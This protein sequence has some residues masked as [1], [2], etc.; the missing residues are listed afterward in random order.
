MASG[1]TASNMRRT[2]DARPF[3]YGQA[4]RRRL[5]P[6]GTA[7]Q[8]AP[9][10]TLYGIPNCDTVKKARTWFEKRGVA[11]KFHDFKKQ[12][13]D[14]DKLEEWILDKGWE[15]LL[16]KSGTTF[17]ALPD[18]LKQD[19]DGDKALMLMMAEPSMIK[20]PIVEG[21]GELIVGYSSTDYEA[22]AL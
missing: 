7:L 3:R 14:K 10:I 13:V 6:R 5:T 8:H 15:V 21:A 20:R 17:R 19:L 11:Y 9:M 4:P 1:G 22:I 18:V 12:G 2:M 16:N